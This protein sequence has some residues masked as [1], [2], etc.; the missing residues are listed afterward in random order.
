VPLPLSIDEARAVQRG[1]HVATQSWRARRRNARFQVAKD[2]FASLHA[3]KVAQPGRPDR[4]VSRRQRQIAGLTPTTRDI[5]F[6]VMAG[7]DGPEEACVTLFICAGISVLRSHGGARGREQQDR[8]PTELI[9]GA[10]YSSMMLSP[11]EFDPARSPGCAVLAGR[12][13]PAKTVRAG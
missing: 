8:P 13:Q 5:S 2:Y 9:A 1:L 6:R 3:G 10:G 4:P 12:C 7:Y 11:Y